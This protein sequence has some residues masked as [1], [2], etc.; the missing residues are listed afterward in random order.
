M[1]RD[2]GE[3]TVSKI[4]DILARNGQTLVQPHAVIRVGGRLLYAYREEIS[5]AVIE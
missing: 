4:R 2:G 3:A 1:A 5:L